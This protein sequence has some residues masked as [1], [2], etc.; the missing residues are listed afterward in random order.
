MDMFPH[1][2][3]VESIA[4]FEPRLSRWTLRSASRELDELMGI[5][6]E[7]KFLVTGDGWRAAAHK[8]VPMAQ[9][10]LNDL[11]AMVDSGAMKASVRVRIAGRRGV[12]QPQVARARPHPPGI[13]LRHPGRRRARAAGAV[14]RRLRRQ[15]PPLRRLRRA[16]VGSRRVPRRQRRPGG[17]GDRAGVGRRG[18]RAARLAGR[19]SDR[20]RRA[21]TIWPWPRGRTRNGAR[22]SAGRGTC[23]PHLK[24]N[25][26]CSSSASPAPNSPRRSATGCS[27]MPAPA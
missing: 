14:R 9:G 1:T 4:V 26:A 11:A 18:L 13:R 23:G 16:P 8:V 2:A 21:T 6:I 5:E 19:G 22:T 12:P 7:R 10:Y 25:A 15:A 20:Q 24:D 27:T 17:R 3:H